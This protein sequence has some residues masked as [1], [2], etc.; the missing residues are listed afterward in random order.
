MISTS[1]LSTDL[2]ITRL[3]TPDFNFFFF[4]LLQEACRILILDQGL[5]PHSQYSTA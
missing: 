4:L 2:R 5:N 1:D 3:V